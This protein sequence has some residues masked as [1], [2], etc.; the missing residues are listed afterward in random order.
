MS[1]IME[2]RLPITILLLSRV[3]TYLHYVESV[4][5]IFVFWVCPPLCPGMPPTRQILKKHRKVLCRTISTHSISSSST[6]VEGLPVIQDDIVG[7]NPS[8][9]INISKRQKLGN[10]IVKFSAPIMA[11]TH[12]IRPFARRLSLP[13]RRFSESFATAVA[14]PFRTHL[15]DID[16]PSYFAPLQLTSETSSSYP[17]EPIEEIQTVTEQEIALE[18]VICIVEADELSY[19]QVKKVTKIKRVTRKMKSLLCSRQRSVT[20][21]GKCSAC[22]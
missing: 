12:S 13:A 6:L 21:P 1:T 2:Q 4:V 3:S 9:Q 17:E 10:A 15:L 19:H 14:T 18:A 5:A 20:L 11:P 16:S 8:D 7:F 22:K